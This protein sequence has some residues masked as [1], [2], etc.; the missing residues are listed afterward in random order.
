MEPHA[1]IGIIGGTG[2]YDMPGLDDV[3]EFAIETPFGAPSTPL[4]IGTLSGRRVAFIARHG[5][6]HSLMPTEV[7]YRAN[8]YALRAVGVRQV[9]SVS[10]VGSLREDL[11]PR[12]VVVPDQV[13]DLT[14]RRPLTFFGDGVVAHVGLG[15]PFE[16]G[17]RHA[18]IEGASAAGLPV[19]PRGTYVTME[20]PQFSTRAESRMYRT[21]GGDIVGMTNGT[22]AR[23]AREAEI[24][25]ATLCVVTDY[26]AWRDEH[27]SVE[28]PE[29][30]AIIRETAA[31][32]ARAA[33][34]AV[35]RAPRTDCAA[36]HSL[37]MGLLTPVKAIPAAAR[38]RLAAILEPYLHA[39]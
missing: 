2:L 11:P 24:A 37:A 12:T 7:P 35:A 9:F 28:A 3:H 5:H 13:L 32:A 18:W 8:L 19:V 27:A 4:R 26:D 34:E 31:A 23:R 22:E 25:D 17:M 21:L 16:A 6:H 30:L 29:I 33:A 36:Y 10:A 14:R 15:D 38:T 1:D 39:K 20:G